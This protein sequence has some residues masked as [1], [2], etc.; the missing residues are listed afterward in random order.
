MN[1]W[2]S[3]LQL[4]IR[5]ALTPYHPPPPI[6]SSSSPS[7]PPPLHDPTRW[8]SSPPPATSS[9]SSTFLPLFLGLP[10]NHRCADCP[11]AHPSWVSMTFGVFVCI[12]CSGT[13]RSLGV[14]T[15]KI[16]S[17]YLDVLDDVAWQCLVELGG[18]DRLNPRFLATYRSVNHGGPPHEH[19]D[20][21]EEKDEE[22]KGK[23]SSWT[24][25]AQFV[26]S[27]RKEAIVLKYQHLA[28]VAHRL[29]PSP[30]P[31]PFLTTTTPLNLGGE[32]NELTQEKEVH[33]QEHR[34][35]L[36]AQFVQAMSTG[37]LY[38]SLG[39][40][41]QGA[42][43]NGV[44]GEHGQSV[45]IH[46][47]VHHHS[48][49][50][51]MALQWHVQVDVQ[52]ALGRSALH[53]CALLNFPGYT[54]QLLKRNANVELRDVHDETPLDIALR[55]EH[56]QVVTV[57]RLYVMHQAHPHLASQLGIHEAMDDLQHRATT[58]PLLVHE[59]SPSSSNSHDP[60]HVDTPP[61]VPVYIDHEH[62]KPDD[63]D[64]DPHVLKVSPFQQYHDD[65]TATVQTDWGLGTRWSTRR[66]KG[67]GGEEEEEEE[68][69]KV[70][71]SS[72]S[73]YG[74]SIT[75]SRSTPISA[76]RS[77][78]SKEEDDNDD[79]DVDNDQE[80]EINPWKE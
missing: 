77:K 7:P 9:S 32:H 50:F 71:S 14:G 23:D 62:H 75:P 2:I 35:F 13:H 64:P 26:Q 40:W 4:E 65:N 18:N 57:L 52:D 5:K 60:G 22:K 33:R 56:V 51:E 11:D 72:L 28:Y 12:D 78:V 3:S 73:S 42:D 45:L 63:E 43:V 79:E 53:Y 54:I 16:K 19:L 70:G 74:F 25:Y 61:R 29:P 39:Y 68:R 59:A 21:D 1:T 41:L 27:H 15:S 38:E 69:N 30:S 80:V 49:V 36:T 76:Q 58:P 55:H 24:A 6:P 37:D 17:V 46:A 31:S 48:K 67:A 34:A 20:D 47:V 8:R 66:E 10:G 44:G